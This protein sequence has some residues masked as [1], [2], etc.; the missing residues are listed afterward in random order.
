MGWFLRERRG[1]QWKQGWME[2]VLCSSSLPP[3][4][5]VLIFAIVMLFLSISWHIDYK[6][7]V[8]R[9]E[10]GFRLVLFLLPVALIVVAGFVLLDRRFL[11]RLPQPQ[12][13]P[14]HRAGSSPWGVALLVV[15]LLFMISYQSSFHSQWFRPLWR[16]D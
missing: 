5:L 3:P 8:R 10:A 4:S 11:F 14:V 16:V 1:P 9:A 13:E 12:Q 6:T 2:R 7:Q 15:V